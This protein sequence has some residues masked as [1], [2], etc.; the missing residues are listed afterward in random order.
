[1]KALTTPA[2]AYFCTVVSAFGVVILGFL[3]M[4]FHQGHEALLGSTSAPEDGVAVSHTLWGAAFVYALFLGFCGC[5]IA[6]IRNNSR[7]KL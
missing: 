3:G 6:V 5:Q 4:L 1:M 2:K 7:I